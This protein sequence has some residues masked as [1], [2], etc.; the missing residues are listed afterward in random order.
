[1]RRVLLVLLAITVACSNDSN[2]ASANPGI[3]ISLE[4][5]NFQPGQHY[6]AVLHN[7]SANQL[8]YRDMSCGYPVEH[9]DGGRWVSHEPMGARC[10]F[11]PIGPGDESPVSFGIPADAP[12]GTYRISLVVKNGNKEVTVYS[13]TF[14]VTVPDS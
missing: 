4:E 14:L 6:T 7:R 12:P 1:M 2:D 11:Y 13:T 3:E 8:R 5:A 10:N 9:R